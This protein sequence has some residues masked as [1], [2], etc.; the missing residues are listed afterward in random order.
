MNSLKWAETYLEIP[1]SYGDALDGL[2]WSPRGDA[3]VR[4]DGTTLAVTDEIRAVLEGVLARPP[5]P[6]FVFVL[7]L[8]HLMKI[9]SPAFE[10]LHWAFKSTRGAAARGRNVGLLIAEL[11]RD[12]PPITGELTSADLT[13]ALRLLRVY[14]D[15]FDS[16]VVLEAP[17]TR[18]EFECRVAYRL[19]DF[20]N[21]ALVHWLKHG[22][23][24]G[25]AGGRLAEQA[26]SLP[27]R[28]AQL[29]VRARRRARLVGAASLVPTLDAALTLPPRGHPPEALPLGGYCDVTTRGR[30][31]RLLPGQFA[32]DPDEFI[33][34]FAA[35]EL[36]YF[37]REEPHQAIRAECV[38]VLDQGVR[39]WGSVRLALAG[40]AFSLLRA[41]SKRGRA[42]LF[43]TSAP[44][45]IDL[46]AP[47]AEAVADRLEASDLTP[48]P[49]ECLTRA[50]RA[51]GGDP[52]D[53][54]LLTH[55]RSLRESVV[56]SAASGRGPGDR[57]FAVTVDE[58]GRA[59][60]MQWA[61]GGPMAVRSFRVDLEAA[62]AACPE[63]VA[64]PSRPRTAAAV[65][66]TGDVEPVPFPFRPGL[67]TEPLLVGFEAGHDWLVIA[68]R[69]GVLH[70][71]ALDGSPPE[72]LPRALRDGVVLKQ[73]EAILGVTSGVV[74]CGR[75]VVDSGPTVSATT[76]QS[77]TLHSH[78]TPMVSS[79]ASE[80]PPHE[81]FVA[82]HY[83]RTTRQVTLHALGPSAAEPRWSAHPDLHCVA[84]RAPAGAGCAL[85]LDT[86]G[87]FSLPGPTATAP[88]NRACLAWNRAAKGAPP[89]DLPIWDSTAKV[90]PPDGVPFTIVLPPAVNSIWDAPFLHRLR[91]NE[92]DLKQA[93]GNWNRLKPQRDGKRLLAG[94]EFHC[95]QL[96]GD[97]LALAYSNTEGRKLLLLRG[98]EGA[99]L[100]EVGHPVHNIFTL[101][102][103]GRLLARRDVARAVVVAET[104]APAQTIASAAHAGLHDAIAVE[105]TAAPFQLTTIVGGH[106]HRFQ[107]ECRLLLH[108]P[109][110]E[111]PD[112]V[113][114]PKGTVLHPL[115][116]YDQSRFPPREIVHVRGWRVVVD[117]LGQV[118]LFRGDA[119]PLVAA[120]LVRR[121]RAAAWVPGGVFW[122]DT[123][124]IGGP[125]TPDA[126]KKIGQA[127]VDAGGV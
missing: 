62:E 78:D 76:P 127:I 52:R 30:P 125:A 98:P 95:A 117:R 33:R 79:G 11:C 43:A 1:S 88:I 92:I 89:Y 74:V 39:T 53:V 121:E 106:Q 93:P 54:I 75:M 16:D 12:L 63:T 50:L 83:V 4:R 109:R 8:L 80:P 105:L 119:G 94:A 115:T 9:D 25:G 101:S 31:E 20:D 18:I 23:G 10:R 67:V 58:S 100:G 64:P 24:P 21:V 55:S 17:L 124:L 60:L 57:L 61:T 90:A 68:G 77:V 7:N 87:R 85:D 41:A 84:V 104:A 44:G 99:V 29:L 45:A 108:K 81:Q 114:R 37:K 102:A 69:D 116:T 2:C 48:H 3:V 26:E 70:G 126:D 51:G 66:W 73:V 91:S 65:S 118:L 34:R 22:C 56:A 71:L 15:R 46:L 49:G 107:L 113:A 38:V 123:R 122:G 86:L 14:G 110:W 47:N 82:A 59:E 13:L 5:I 6:P 97:V 111:L 96:A 27:G 28:I 72:V 32:L 35:N 112:R 120:F 42:W 103:D 40:A 19:V 36:L